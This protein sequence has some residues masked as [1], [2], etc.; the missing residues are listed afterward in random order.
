MTQAGLD[1]YGRKGLARMM[2]VGDAAAMARSIRRAVERRK[3]RLIYPRLFTVLRWFPG[4][5]RW[6][7]ERFAPRL[8]AAP[9]AK[10]P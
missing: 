1:R 9:R 4:V 2:P 6:F 7:A 8:D 5:S 10:A 3:R